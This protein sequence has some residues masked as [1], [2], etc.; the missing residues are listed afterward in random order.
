MLGIDTCLRKEIIQRELQIATL[1]PLILVEEEYSIACQHQ[2][3]V[4][5][6]LLWKKENV[7]NSLIDDGWRNL[8]L[9]CI[10]V[11]DIT[12]LAGSI[13]LLSATFFAFIL[14]LK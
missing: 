14:L 12:P 11:K 6:T 7:G 13:F 4:W 2:D 10:Q 5:A 8:I 3:K 9:L 1:S